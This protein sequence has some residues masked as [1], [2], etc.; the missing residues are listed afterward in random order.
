M[1]FPPTHC[2]CVCGVHLCV[3]VCARVYSA[4]LVSLTFVYFVSSRITEA[5]MDV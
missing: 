1:A 5:I 3:C 2:V 4:Q